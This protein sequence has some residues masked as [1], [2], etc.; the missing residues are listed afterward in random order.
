MGG[1]FILLIKFSRYGIN[2]TVRDGK[3]E[4]DHDGYKFLDPVKDGSVL[5]TRIRGD[6]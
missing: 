4:E 2:R 5:P 6:N 3:R 1:N